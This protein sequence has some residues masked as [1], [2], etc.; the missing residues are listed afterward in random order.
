MG[1]LPSPA[2][3]CLE[4]PGWLSAGGAADVVPVPAGPGGCE[5]RAARRPGDGCKSRG[6]SLGSWLGRVGG[7]GG[8]GRLEGWAG[9]WGV[10]LGFG[11]LGG[12]GVG[13]WVEGCW[14]FGGVGLG[15]GWVWGV[16][17]GWRVGGWGGWVGGLGWGGWRVGGLGGWEAGLGGWG[18]G[19]G[20]GSGFGGGGQGDLSKSSITY[21]HSSICF[22][23]YYVD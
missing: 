21:F 5:G 9:G 15:G 11:G 13:G 16:E 3:A 12:W 18:W 23:S 7:L 4:A 20:W 19:V 17:Q 8:A 6:G 10:G 14:G 2:S 1:P 22:Q